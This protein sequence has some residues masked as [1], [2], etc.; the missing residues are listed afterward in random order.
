MN[1][2]GGNV[3]STLVIWLIILV[4][5]FLVCREIFCWYWKVNQSIALLTE[6]RDHLARGGVSAAAGL[7]SGRIESTATTQA[8]LPSKTDKLLRQMVADGYTTAEISK[9]LQS[10]HGMNAADA[11]SQAI[12]AKGA[13]A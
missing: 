10:Q 3:T 5:I 1:N 9:R 13:S 7:P 8:A 4:I 12:A 6:I 11:D 2:F